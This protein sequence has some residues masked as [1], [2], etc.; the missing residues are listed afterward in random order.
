MRGTGLIP[1][2]AKNDIV[3]IFPQV[4]FSIVQY[5][6]SCPQIQANFY[7]PHG[8]WNFIGY[9]PEDADN[10]QFATKQGTQMRVVAKM[11]E[12]AAQISMF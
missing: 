12:K 3:M 9:L 7:N 6:N 1:L 4:S 11:V 8:C 2:A 10:Y 5:S